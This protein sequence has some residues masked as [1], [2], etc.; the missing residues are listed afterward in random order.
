MSG[1]VTRRKQVWKEARRADY[2]LFEHREGMSR[3]GSSSNLKILIKLHKL[4]ASPR[5]EGFDEAGCVVHIHTMKRNIVKGSSERP[6][7]LARKWLI[8]FL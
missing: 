5:S 3:L 8:S 2:N 1:A 7:T 4:I 6:I